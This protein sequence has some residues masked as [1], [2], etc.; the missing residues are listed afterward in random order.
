MGYEIGVARII[1]RWHHL[2]DEFKL[3]LGLFHNCLVSTYDEEKI[4]QVFVIW[5]FIRHGILSKL[6]WGEDSPF[7]F[8]FTVHNLSC[9]SFQAQQNLGRVDIAIFILG[10]KTKHTYKQ[11]PNTSSAFVSCCRLHRASHHVIYPVLQW[12][13]Q[14]ILYTWNK[15]LVFDHPWLVIQFSNY[16]DHFHSLFLRYLSFFYFRN[17]LFQQLG[18]RD[19]SIWE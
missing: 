12:L 16:T 5:W 2:I 11:K 13:L 1:L 6:L 4:Y 18:S 7:C 8:Y 14:N 15:L 9:L 3:D 10:I 19:P 17:S